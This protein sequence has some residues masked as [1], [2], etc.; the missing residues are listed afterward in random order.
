M[1]KFDKLYESIITKYQ[2]IGTCISTV[3]DLCMWDATEMAQL[4]DNSE[5][6][7]IGNILPF[8]NQE[9]KNKIY[10]TPSNFDCGKL[11]NIAWIYDFDDDMHYFYEIVKGN[12]K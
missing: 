7:D 12:A 5:P 1:Y 2:Y 8:V 6:F 11:K 4:I 3:D 9:L 10:D